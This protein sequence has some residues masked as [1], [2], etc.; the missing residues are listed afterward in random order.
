MH[1]PATPDGDGEVADARRLGIYYTPDDVAAVLV[2]W[3]L[4]QRT[5]TV[6]DPSFGGCSILRAALA[7]EP[8]AGSNG[9]VAVFGVDIDPGARHHARELH[10][11]GVPTANLV[12]GDFFATGPATFGDRRFDAVIANPPYI[13]HHWHQGDSRTLAKT[14]AETDGVTLPG[15]ADAWA[16][17]V[18]HSLGFLRQGGRLAF[19]LP[20]AILHADY[21]QSLLEHLSTRF[22]DVRLVELTQRLFPDAA[23]A[24][25][26]L[27]ASGYMLSDSARMSLAR[28]SGP[29]DLARLLRPDA[30]GLPVTWETRRMWPLLELPAA[31]QRAWKQAVE[32]PLVH[33]L[34][35]LAT[36]RIGVV[37]GANSFFVRSKSEMDALR[38]SHVTGQSLVSRAADLSGCRIT[39]ADMRALDRRGRATRLLRIAPNGS[40]PTGLL[41]AEIQRAEESAL[42]ERSHCARREPWYSIADVAVPDAFLPYMGTRPTRPVLNEARATCTNAIHRL[43]WTAP[44]THRPRNV[45]LGAW[46][47]L[48]A[49]GAEVHGR[50][51]GGGVLKLEPSEA[52]LVPVPV[53]EAADGALDALDALLR[54]RRFDAATA[55]ADHIVLAQ[56]LGFDAG[57]VAAL[58]E[59]ASTLQAQRSS[60]P[61]RR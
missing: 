59:A 54:Y 48:Y 50:R 18:I 8:G 34:G 47:S 12:Q 15:R 22:E 17:F 9:N 31:A 1:Q 33:T 39:K 25:V 10:K 53:V 16:F 29:A 14:V 24:S 19:L 27:V 52:G 35:D 43:W 41:R 37:T 5:G 46:T 60:S 23:E 4:P 55:L 3:A 30:A 36:I 58:R 13:R 57:R 61:Q 40:A 11:L 7:L 21:A 44:T 2:R 20:A 42:H 26:V 38:Q 56:G 45:V 28:G 51:Y 49:L 6:L 32:S